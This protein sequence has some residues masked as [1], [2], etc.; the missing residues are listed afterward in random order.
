MPCRES[1]RASS[2]TPRLS[3]TETRALLIRIM[4]PLRSWAHGRNPSSPVS[5]CDLLSAPGGCVMIPEPITNYLYE[6]AV[7]FRASEHP[8]DV[9]AQRTAQAAHVSGRRFGKTVV[10]EQDGRYYLVVLPA[11]EHLDLAAARELLGPNVRLA[12]E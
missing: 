4:C 12:S 9:T 2:S 7:P 3:E 11:T 10:L 6:H 1:P 5:Q 8:Y